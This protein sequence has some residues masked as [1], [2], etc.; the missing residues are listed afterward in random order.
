MADAGITFKDQIAFAFA[1]GNSKAQGPDETRC[2][3]TGQ[4]LA[5]GDV[6]LLTVDRT[7]QEKGPYGSYDYVHC[8][9]AKLDLKG[10]IKSAL[11][12]P[13]FTGWLLKILKTKFLGG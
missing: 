6:V 10:M 4:K 5:K 7:G 8:L 13:E 3:L 12:D 9:P 2:A 11:D 1:H